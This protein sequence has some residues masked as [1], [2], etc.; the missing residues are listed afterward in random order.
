MC[1]NPYKGCDSMIDFQPL[2]LD[3]QSLCR[4]HLAC[5]GKRGCEYN[6]TNLYLWGRQKAAFVE[7]HL[8]IFSQYGRQSFYLFPVGCNDKKAVLSAL[9]ED[10]K[11]RGIACRFGGMTHD[12][13]ALLVKLF[14]GQF[15]YHFDR[16]SF[17][18]VY[19]IED[20]AELKGK[21]YQK[22]RNH[23]NRFRQSFPD[24][25]FVPITKDI[26]PAVSQMVENWY[27]LRQQE[28][29][30]MD[31]HMERAALAKALRDKNV[32]MRGD[33]GIR[34]ILNDCIE[35]TEQDYGTEYLDYIVSMRT[36]DSVEEAIDHINRYN[37]RH[38]ESIITGNESHAQQ[39][40]NGVDAACVYVNAS[41]RFT[42]GFEFG[43]G[44][45]IGISTQKLHARGPMGL[46]ELTSY[47]YMVRG[48]GQIRG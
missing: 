44:A 28:Q 39:F 2:S 29:P 36:V 40:L 35:A 17:D 19:A 7:G 4:A 18:Y 8:V 9:I 34:E 11:Q 37:T 32:E 27:A 15:R 45:E 21:K 22:K 38:S 31:F 42:D 41:T 33:E 48:C 20:L 26:L 14:P 30:H 5:G 12:D 6:F 13:C 24:H 23:L 46:K 1:Y 16:D 47:K 3:Q 25:S 10:A 43:F